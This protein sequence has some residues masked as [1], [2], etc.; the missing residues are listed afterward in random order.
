MIFSQAMNGQSREVLMIIVCCNNKKSGGV[1]T[2][3]REASIVNVLRREVADELVKARSQIFDWISKGGKTCS[4]ETMCDLPR[5]Q[6]LVKG[7]DFGGEANDARYLRAAERYQGAFYSELGDH[8]P[9]LLTEGAASVLILSGL[10]GI[11]RPAESIQDHVCHFNDHP[12]I[13]ETLT[14]KNLLT[15]AVN[16]FI[17]ARGIRTVLDFTTLHSYRYLLD[18]DLIARELRGGIL[19]LFGEQTTGVELSVPL[20]YA[21]G[22]LLRSSPVDLQFLHPG[23]F[24]ETPTDRVYFHSGGTVPADL[25]PKLRDELELFESCHEVVGMARFIRR[26]LDERDPS[27]EDRDVALRIGSL[28]HQGMMSADVTHAMTDIVRWC[29]HVE[30]HFT[31][32]AQQ[33][34]LDWLRKRYD[35]VRDWAAGK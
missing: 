17:R 24:L 22:C 34:P 28:E 12:S 20:G 35:V 11:L 29:K 18:W 15:R 19:H 1:S 33:I 14:R 4:G 13:R 27:S 32:A 31:F 23:K 3:D 6:G 10:Y 30:A 26:I 2:Y 5:N 9:V 25:P 7:P 16:D 21:A 8:G